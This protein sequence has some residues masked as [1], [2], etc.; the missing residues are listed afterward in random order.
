MS[1]KTMILKYTLLWAP[2]VVIAIINGA[3]R[4][5]TYRDYVGDLAAHQLSTAICIIIL[6]MYIWALGLRWKL[7]SA[8]Q[9]V[10][11]GLI[12]LALTLAFEFLFFHYAAGHSW[13][14]LLDSYNI[15]DGKVWVLVPIFIAIA[16]YLSYRMHS[17]Q[18]K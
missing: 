4:D 14:V 16:P 7:E 11:V 9:A 5:M 8:G 2:M 1:G 10:A 6:C 18:M 17:R 12:W 3:L 13:S 15:L